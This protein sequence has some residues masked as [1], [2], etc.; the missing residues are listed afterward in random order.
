MEGLTSRILILGAVLLAAGGAYHAM[1]KPSET[2]KTEEWLAG[3]L[4]TQIGNYVV[5]SGPEGVKYSYKMDERTYNLL[6]PY[7]IN[8]RTFQGSE[9]VVD[10][11]V[12]G[13]RQKESFHDPRQ[14]FSAQAFSLDEVTIKPFETKSHGTLNATFVKLKGERGNQIAAFMYKGPKGYTA[15]NKDVKIDMFLDQLLSGGKNLDSVFYRFILTNSDDTKALT[16][17]MG[18]WFDAANET[19]KGVF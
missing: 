12:I 13:S 14:C 10:V 8:A 11:V 2:T 15:Q 18:Q 3:Q 6:Q 5:N 16:D 19:S 9:H 4:P 17:F 7:G 1:P